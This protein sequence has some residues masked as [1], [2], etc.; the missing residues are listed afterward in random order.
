M[1]VRATKGFVDDVGK[2]R[3]GQVLDLA[4]FRGADLVKRGLAVDIQGG[5]GKPR[6]T[7]SPPTKSR[8][9]GEKQPLSLPADQ[10][11]QRQKSNSPEGEQKSSRSTRRGSSRRSRTSS[12]PAT[13]PGGD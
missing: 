2:V 4:D 7:R 12:T 6:P 3:P 9:G 13:E 11:P 10:V 1:L 5:G 8:I